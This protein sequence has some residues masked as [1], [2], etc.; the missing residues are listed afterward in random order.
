MYNH[1]AKSYNQL[2]EQ[3]QLKKLAIIKKNIK[4]IPPL[5]DIGCGTGISTN[6]FNVEAV[7]I[8]NC[9][10][11][12]EEGKKQ[13]NNLQYAQAEKLPF[14]DKSFSTIIS[15]TAFHN[16]K[17]MDKALK[18]IKRVSKNNNIAIS[19]L[20]KSKKLNEFR[21]LLKKYYNFKEIEEEKDIIFMV[22]N[23][24]KI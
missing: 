6:Y 24:K 10:E 1:I 2:H 21:T 11:M 3:E 16:F 20:K 23:K 14:K 7:G 19:F 8:D 12:L 9:K 5:L 22:K 13:Y 17:N 15:V 18:E 4:L